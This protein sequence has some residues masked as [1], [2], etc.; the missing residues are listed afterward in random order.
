V[1]T[2][3]QRAKII[4]TLYCFSKVPCF[5]GFVKC[6]K[7]FN[8]NNMHSQVQ[9]LEKFKYMKTLF[10][11]Q[12]LAKLNIKKEILG[13]NASCQIIIKT[14]WCTQTTFVTKE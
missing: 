5:K 14:S 11:E 1:K 2:H 7:G 3:L 4:I 10:Y 12:N 6:L 13:N 9:V 8:N